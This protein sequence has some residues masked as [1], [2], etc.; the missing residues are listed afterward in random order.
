MQEVR[1]ILQMKLVKGRQNYFYNKL[2]IYSFWRFDCYLIGY[3]AGC[4]VGYHTD[5]VA[6]KKHYRLN[7]QLLGKNRLCHTDNFL[8]LRG[9]FDLFRADRM[10]SFGV[11]LEKGLILSFGVCI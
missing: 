8:K 10:H 5:D 2:K 7:I 3:S 1:G 11:T 4:A 9:R 6:N